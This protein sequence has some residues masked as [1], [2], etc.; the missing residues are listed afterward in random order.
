MPQGLRAL[1]KLIKI[2]DQEMEAIGAEKIQMPSLVPQRLWEKTGTVHCIFTFP[3]YLYS[4]LNLLNL[5]F[6]STWFPSTLIRPTPPQTSTRYMKISSLEMIWFTQFVN[7]WVESPSPSASNAV[8]CLLINEVFL[9][10]NLITVWHFSIFHLILAGRWEA[11]GS[12]LFR[13]QDRHQR[14]YCLGPV[15]QIWCHS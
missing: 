6:S 8:K 11:M 4:I 13:L 7:F 10:I 14:G 3:T 12:E 5:N 1:Q 9:F 15:S 2:I